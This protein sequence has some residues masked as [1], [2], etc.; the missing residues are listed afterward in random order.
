MRLLLTVV[1]LFILSLTFVYGGPVE[2]LITQAP[3]ELFE[4]A[5]LYK[6]IPQE[7]FIGDNVTI[8]VVLQDISQPQL[9]AFIEEDNQ[10]GEQFSPS[11]ISS[12][13]HEE[14]LETLAVL[15]WTLPLRQNNNTYT[16]F[17]QAEN[18]TLHT[19]TFSIR[20]IEKK[21]ISRR[22]QEHRVPL[23]TEDIDENIR[24]LLADNGV[25][26]SLEDFEQ[27]TK[28]GQA[29]PITKTL[30]TN[31]TFYEDNSSRTHV[32]VSLQIPSLP[33]N[34]SRVELVE[35]IPKELLSSAQN[36][37]F[38]PQAIVLKDDPVIMWH[39]DDVDTQRNLSYQV[40][41]SKNALQ[42]TGNTVALA[43][44]T[45]KGGGGLR[46]SILAPLLLIP[47]IGAIVIYFARFAPREK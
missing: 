6:D 23:I 44:V 14:T 22:I 2:E 9:N 13:N 34:I 47:L 43:H 28:Q 27:L 25:D 5:T 37:V 7:G 38:T 19:T 16:L 45:N 8:T 17:I 18:A 4:G 32:A 3:V 15:T 39:L 26:Y 31:T 29:I 24:Q 21:I 33:D 10:K 20:G 46:W 36:A 35:V 41:N 12:H 11:N 40:N 30:T 42:L 1:V